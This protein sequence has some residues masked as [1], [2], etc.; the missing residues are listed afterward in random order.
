MKTRYCSFLLVSERFSCFVVFSF[1]FL[2]V[3]VDLVS[4][5]ALRFGGWL[6]REFREAFVLCFILAF[7]FAD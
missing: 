1:V 2:F 7:D 5:F 4:T 6:V 3:L